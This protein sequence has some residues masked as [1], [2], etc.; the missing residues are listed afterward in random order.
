MAVLK[1]IAIGIGFVLL[2][3]AGVIALVLGIWGPL[4][5]ILKMKISGWL[6]FPL[7]VV[8]VGIE[9]GITKTVMDYLGIE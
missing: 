5:L 3:I 6:G 7:Y 4:I 9:I 8:M 1:N 2:F